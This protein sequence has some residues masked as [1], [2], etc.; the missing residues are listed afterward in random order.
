VRQRPIVVAAGVQCLVAM[1]S[2]V[3]EVRR[4]VFQQRSASGRVGH[5]ERHAV[6]A[7]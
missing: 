3:H 5:D 1:Q 6:A 4:H 7:Q 2:Q